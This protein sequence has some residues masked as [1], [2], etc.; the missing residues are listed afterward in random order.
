MVF[1]GFKFQN[2]PGACPRILLV[3]RGLGATVS[4]GSGS[5]PGSLYVISSTYI[6]KKCT[7]RKTRLVRLWCDNAPGQCCLVFY[8]L[9]SYFPALHFPRALSHNKRTRLVFYF[10]NLNHVYAVALPPRREKSN[11]ISTCTKVSA[12]FP[13]AHGLHLE[14]LFLFIMLLFRS[15]CMV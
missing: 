15:N 7:Y 6:I 8:T 4:F 9:L 3:M 10:L 1:P 14:I 12:A 13:S 2:F 11:L 5:A